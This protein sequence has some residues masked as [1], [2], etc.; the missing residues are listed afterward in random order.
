M[1]AS[2]CAYIFLSHTLPSLGPIIS[3][4][5][6]DGASLPRAGGRS[7]APVLLA[8]ARAASLAIARAAE[9]IAVAAGLKEG[10]TG[11]VSRSG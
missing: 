2:Y 7:L 9:V 3:L 1:L 5:A 4:A 11:W 10:D 8:A 6:F